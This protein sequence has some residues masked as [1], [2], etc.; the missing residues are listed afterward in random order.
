[1]EG[2]E[3]KTE[4]VRMCSM[5]PLTI[6][7]LHAIQ[8]AVVENAEELIADAELLQQ[9]GRFARAFSLAVLA[10]EELAKSPMFTGA[11]PR[12][13]RG[14]TGRLAQTPTFSADSRSQARNDVAC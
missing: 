5:N 7:Q 10:C 4:T 1:M 11:V 2:V 8:D 13:C 3:K 6:T 9:H 14:G 12:H